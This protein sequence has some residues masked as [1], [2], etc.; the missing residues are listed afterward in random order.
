[1]TLSSASLRVATLC[2]SLGLAGCAPDPAAASASAY[3]SPV[4]AS[5]DASPAG[6]S[7]CTIDASGGDIA[8]V[9]QGTTISGRTVLWQTPL[10]APPAAGWPVVFVFQGS[11]FAPD[12]MWSARRSDLLGIFGTYTQTMMVK[13]LLDGGYVVVTPAADLNAT[14]WDTNL[15]PWRDLWQPA[16]DNHFL[17]DLFA[18]VDG[19]GFGAVDPARWYA[20]GVSSG[21]Y[22]TSRMAVSYAGRFRALAVSAGSYA[23]CG[24][25]LCALP[26]LLPADHPPTLFLHGAIDPVV[27]IATMYAYRDALSALGHTT[28]TVVDPTFMHGWIPATPDEVRAWFDA[29]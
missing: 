1:M 13:R 5:S 10:G 17:V 11:F 6:P 19:G 18:A 25:I 3:A 23:T 21:G 4:A 2:A 29:H 20:T 24:G 9:Y 7:R 27:P 8:C 12:K 28:R 22:M 26:P 16:P 14:A 15:V